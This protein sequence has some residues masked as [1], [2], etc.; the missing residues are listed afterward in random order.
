MDEPQVLVI[1]TSDTWTR[2]AREALETIRTA[3]GGAD[4][5]H[6]ADA[7][8]IAPRAFGSLIEALVALEPYTGLKVGDDLIRL[9]RL[10]PATEVVF[11][12]D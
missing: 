6:L 8:D 9:A 2:Q 4:P 3:N 5:A 12:G 7:V 1:K 11:G 10:R